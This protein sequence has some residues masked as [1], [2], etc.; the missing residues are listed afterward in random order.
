M[1]G[2]TNAIHSRT[3]G[4]AVEPNFIALNGD[5]VLRYRLFHL[6]VGIGKEGGT[7]Q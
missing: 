6:V 2:L 7:Q 3:N 5:S 1:Q 4:K